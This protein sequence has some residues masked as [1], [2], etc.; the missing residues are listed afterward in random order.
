MAYAAPVQSAVKL[1]TP[2]S[3]WEA[4]LSV[5]DGSGY[6]AVAPPAK[7]TGA[8][9][10]STRYV[11]ANCTAQLTTGDADAELTIFVTVSVFVVAAFGLA[12]VT[13]SDPSNSR[14]SIVTS[15]STVTVSAELFS[16]QNLHS[17]SVNDSGCGDQLA[18]LA[19]R[20]SPAAPVQTENF[21]PYCTIGRPET[22]PL[23][24]A[25]DASGSELT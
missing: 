23:A 10:Q 4:A 19:K 5:V 25:W 22:S 12:S 6:V 1:I 24:C 13:T 2:V 15:A 14:L 8:V 16:K 9:A 3:A 7:L 11:S 17:G 18:A 20:P 21:E